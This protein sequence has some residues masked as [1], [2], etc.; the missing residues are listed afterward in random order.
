MDVATEGFGGDSVYVDNVVVFR[1]TIS[2]VIYNVLFFLSVI[3][4]SVS[5]IYFVV[6]FIVLF[7]IIIFFLK[8]Y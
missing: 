6:I 4:V 8:S 1:K 3:L 7:L 2:A 5:K